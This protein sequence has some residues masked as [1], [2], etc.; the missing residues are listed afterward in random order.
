[1]N[2]E[3]RLRR[4]RTVREI[5]NNADPHTKKRLLDLAARYEQAVPRQST[6]IPLAGIG[7][8]KQTGRN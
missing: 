4:A 7:M 8:L 3:F 6:P 2:E 5:A 1:M